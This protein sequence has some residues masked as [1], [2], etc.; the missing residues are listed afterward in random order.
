M[1]HFF[2]CIV[3]QELLSLSYEFHVTVNKKEGSPTDQSLALLLIN[4]HGHQM[5]YRATML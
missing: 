1:R 2:Y 3:L 4:Y 5:V